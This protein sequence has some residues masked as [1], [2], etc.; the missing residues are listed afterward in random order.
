MMPRSW[1]YW[2]RRECEFFIWLFYVLHAISLYSLFFAFSFDYTLVFSQFIPLLRF[3]VFKNITTDQ[4]SS[5]T[6]NLAHQGDENRIRIESYRLRQCAQQMWTKGPEH[7]L[8]CLLRPVLPSPGLYL[9][10]FFNHVFWLRVE[11]LKPPP[12]SPLSLI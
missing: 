7:L 10:L 12:P 4:H 6:K 9:F 1:G 2:E 11:F 3:L 8:C 5:T